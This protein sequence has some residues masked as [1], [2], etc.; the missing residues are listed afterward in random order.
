MITIPYLFQGTGAA[1]GQI[2]T[3]QAV[4]DGPIVAVQVTG[5]ILA[6]TAADVNAVL[7]LAFVT[8]SPG[9]G[10]DSRSVIAMLY[11]ALL[12]GDATGHGDSAK[13]LALSGLMIPWA[14]G[15]RLYLNL[16]FTTGSGSTILGSAV[17]HQAVDDKN[18]A[19]MSGRLI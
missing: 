16:G 6:T 13:V 4:A 14:L 9:S 2:Q 7:S 5:A 3:V 19:R 11:L 17:V 10:T 12:F 15:E 1:A 18:Y 8:P